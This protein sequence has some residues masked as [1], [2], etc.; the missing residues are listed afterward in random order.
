MT[1]TSQLDNIGENE[2]AHQKNESTDISNVEMDEWIAQLTTASVQRAIEAAESVG[3]DQLEIQSLAEKMALSHE[4]VPIVHVPNDN[5][6]YIQVSAN[7]Q[8]S[9]PLLDCG[10][11]VC[12]ISYTDEEEIKKYNAK[13][14]PCSMSVT[15]VTKADHQVTGV[16]WLNYE[17]GKRRAY[18]P[19]VVMKSHR[20]YFIVGINFWRAFDIQLIWGDACTCV[21]KAK[22]WCEDGPAPIKQ[23]LPIIRA[24][25]RTSVQAINHGQ[26]NPDFHKTET[27]QPNQ[28][29]QHNAAQIGMI[30][31]ANRLSAC[32][33]SRLKLHLK[34]NGPGWYDEVNS[35]KRSSNATQYKFAKGRKHVNNV[36]N[37]QFHRNVYTRYESEMDFE[38]IEPNQQAPE[39]HSVADF[40]MQLMIGMPQSNASIAEVSVQPDIITA[41]HHNDTYVDVMPQKHSCVTKPH[42]LTLEQQSELDAVMLEFP[43]TATTGP[44][45]CTHIYTQ[46]ID[47]GNA[48]PEMRRQ[49]QMSPYVLAEVENEIK[50]LIERDIIEPI[51]FSAWRWP[52]L[53]VKKKS[54]GGRICV[55]ARGLNK[56]TIRDAYPTLKV[57]V[58]LQNL[59]NAKF[60]S[61]LDMTAAFHQIAIDPA[62]RDKT[63]F[64]VGH[65]FYRYKR[66]LMG[67]TNSP[68]HLAKVLDKVFGDMMPHVYHYVDDFIIL[69]ATFDEHIKLLREVARRLKDANLTVSQEK[70][71]FCCKQVTFLGYVLAESGLAPNMDRVR[72]ILEYKRPTTVKELRRLIGLIGWYR[73]FLPNISET[74]APLTDLA[75][76]ESKSKIIWNESAEEAFERVKDALMSPNI[77]APADPKLP[78]KIYTDASLVAGAAVL[79]QIQSGR[80]RVIAYHSAKFSQTQQNYSATERECL[81]VLMGIEKFRPYVDGIRFTVIT[82]HA[83]LRW[84]QNLKE[85]HGKLARWAVRLQAFDVEFEHRPGKYMTVP[86]ALSRSV[87]II[88]L[89]NQTNSEDAWYT[90]MFKLASKGTARKYKIS[91]KLLY[92]LGRYDVRTGERK[93]S[94]CVPKEKRAE[95]LADQ[96]DNQSHFGYWKTL[97]MMQRMY[98]W[99]R[100]YEDI[101]EYIRSCNTCKQIKP[102]NENTRVPIGSYR[103][104]IAVGRV[105]SLDL[106]GPLPASRV[107]KHIWAIVVVDVFSKYTFAK[108]CTRATA[109]VIAD[110]LEKEIFYKFETPE[111]MITD[112]GAQFT[113]D[114][115]KKFVTEHGIEH[116]LTP[117]Y[118]PQSNPVESTN[119]S[120]KQLLRAELLEKADH[121]DWSSYLQK[122]VMRL[123]TTPRFP[124]GFSPH[125]LAYGREKAQKGVEHKLLA[126]E[127]PELNEEAEEKR[128]LIYSQAAEE[129]R[130]MFEKNK[131]RYNLRASQRKFKE[132]DCVWIKNM[133]QSVA[134]NDYTQKLAPIRKMVYIKRA[135]P[136]T[137]DMYEVIDSKNK[138]IGVYHATDIQTR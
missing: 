54:G 81:A 122:C 97:K 88:N 44:L 102:T 31:L 89:E 117:V 36:T 27:N 86:D 55:D 39:H 30:S 124:T 130:A 92:H 42:Q 114:F 50:Q 61:C 9:Y 106:I 98:Y 116:M 68:A 47:T 34:K 57:D 38:N 134:G 11:M 73:R 28:P 8:N 71:V 23:V 21:P 77:L 94:L 125:F 10:A 100:M 79:T 19:T 90:A 93:W 14:R 65:R 128:E 66:A 101:A 118:H 18:I 103:D 24:D 135:V 119:K 63:A 84:L 105:I 43:Y 45:N 12:V 127:N 96:H 104:P 138:L 129:Q 123:N 15:T 48:P 60:I 64:A 58:I 2:T 76:G 51:D 121:V 6:P 69:S 62:D 26:T 99:P 131:A 37:A 1:Q 46:R 3:Y 53:W 133:R 33:T 137:S 72:P 120:V 111:V 108:P 52:I 22:P 40:A 29:N 59:P 80:E 113:S 56:I 25:E 20:S 109:N 85:P 16:M 70:S 13:V 126:D 17:I 78:Y 49:Y 5:R 67:F 87:D 41:D 35:K 115:F 83:S 107:H 4:T 74:M 112:N 132:G 110:F 75:K 95:A 91:N 7:N 136:N 82:D 32:Q